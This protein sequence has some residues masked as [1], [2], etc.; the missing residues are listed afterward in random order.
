[1]GGVV[2]AC[3]TIHS[4]PSAVSPFPIATALTKEQ[5]LDMLQARTTGL[6][7]LSAVLAVSYTV[8]KQQGAFDLVVNYDTAGSMRFTAL[9]ESFLSTQILFDL[10][11]QRDTYTFMVHEESGP[12]TFQGE[13]HDFAQAHPTF[14]TF[15]LVGDAFFLPGI[16]GFQQTPRSNNA[17]TRLRT[18]LR[19]GAQAQWRAK[20][21]TLKIIAGCLI[22]KDATGQTISVTIQYAD[23]RPYGMYSLPH[24]VILRDRRAG[25]QATSVI[26]QVDINVPLPPEVFHMAPGAS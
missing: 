22:W 17:G 9:K 7:T 2:G 10:L 14:R 26:K 15:F 25:F 8:G 5:R 23:Y 24:H 1:M 21:E 3:S 13:L 18:R 4:S 6:R 19:S 20:R 11:L 16:D 12:R